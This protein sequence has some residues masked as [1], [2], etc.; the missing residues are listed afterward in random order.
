MGLSRKLAA[1]EAAS[2]EDKGDEGTES[3]KAIAL[4]MNRDDLGMRKCCSPAKFT[5]Y[6]TVTFNA[7]RAGS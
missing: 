6:V 7:L 3:E 4:L 2:S 5:P 1:G